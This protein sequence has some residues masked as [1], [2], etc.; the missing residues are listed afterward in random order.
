MT[1][2][3]AIKRLAG[4]HLVRF[5]RPISSTFGPPFSAFEMAAAGPIPIS[6]DHPGHLEGDQFPQ[7][8]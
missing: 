2:A 1:S 5:E 7:W 4:E 6:S 8:A 3:H